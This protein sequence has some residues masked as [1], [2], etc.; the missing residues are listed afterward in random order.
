[1]PDLSV[2]VNCRDT[3]WGEEVAIVGSW[4]AWNKNQFTLLHTT[5]SIFPAWQTTLSLPNANAEEAIEYKYV[6]VKNGRI[7]KWEG[8][9]SRCNRVTTLSKGNPRPDTYGNIP[10]E[11]PINVRELVGARKWE[12]SLS[13]SSMSPNIHGLTPL[14]KAIVQMTITQKSWRQRLAFVRTLFTDDLAAAKADFNPNSIEGLATISIYLSFLGNGQVR[15]EED[16][17]HHRPNHHA[18]EAQQL[19]SA[20]ET[21]TRNVLHKN[22][23][24]AISSESYIPYIIRKIFPQLPSYST[25]FT[26]SVPL[27]RIRDIAH[28]NDIPHDFKQEIKHTLQNKLHRCAG[29]EDLHTSARLLEKI[30]NGNFNQD[31]KEQFAIFHAELCQFFNASSL[32]GRLEYLRDSEQT[33]AVSSLSSLLISAKTVQKSAIDQLKIVT[34]L[35]SKLLDL[36]TMQD[37]DSSSRAQLPSEHVQKIRLSDIDLETYAFVLLASIAGD[38]DGQHESISNWPLALEGLGLALTNI[39]LSCVNPSEL[40]AAAAELS[41]LS[42]SAPI[43][44]LGTEF[45]LRT[46]AAVDRPLRFSHHFSTAITEVYSKRAASLGKALGVDEHSV[47]VFA[48]AEIRS[49]ATFQASRIADTLSRVLRKRLKL[50][51][52]DPLLTGS[53]SGKVIFSEHLSGIANEDEAVIAICRQADGDEDIPGC[54]KGVVLARSVPHLS[55]LGVRARQAGVVFV[56]AEDRDAFETVWKR[57]DLR[58]AKMVVTPQEGLS[59]SAS[60]GRKET[61]AGQIDARTKVAKVSIEYD[62]NEKTP[63]PVVKATRRSTSSK[64]F[65][66]GQLTN[67]SAENKGLFSSAKAI[68]LPHG[69]FQEHRKQHSKQYEELIAQYDRSQVGGS[70]ADE[71]ILNIREFVRDNFVLEDR[72][73]ENV[74]RS[75]EKGTKVMVR[76]SANAEDLENMS[77]AGLYD[78]IANIDVH[79]TKA[80]R[81][82][83]SNVWGSLWTKRAASSRSWYGVEHKDVSMAVLIQEMVHSD[84]CFVGFSQD[85]IT[86]DD[87]KMYIEMAVGMGEILASGGDEGSAYRLKVDRNSL[88]VETAS[89]ASFSHGLMVDADGGLQKRII[90]YSGQLL[91]RDAEFRRR[92]GERIA[93]SIL[94]IEGVFGGAQDVEGAVTMKNGEVEIFVVQARPQVL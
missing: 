56:C 88:S 35:R 40:A 50:P 61:H 24:D 92:L 29:P 19:E 71:A 91:T 28:R 77:G 93:K 64:C 26:T 45:A 32:D 44:N 74:Q 68:A 49:N 9:G 22:K 30:N 23:N 81:K 73:C 87:S 14:E 75:F 41:Y 43:S 59:L 34:Q 62:G 27:T 11:R 46:K 84:I 54:V 4:N 79:S 18:F 2:T 94:A 5:P 85:P 69:M 58:D 6:I 82:A 21:I 51:P 63:I 3:K 72:C 80:L 86:K 25:Q 16:G 42:Q 53:A 57:K 33:R 55:H 10:S 89:F 48:E 76:S 67:I 1:M 17:G 20:L 38:V 65:F 31:V 12:G 60:P 90:D 66:V 8:S 70:E 78:S 36:P 37:R 47:S 39:G 13:K 52:W 15:C 7:E 83:V